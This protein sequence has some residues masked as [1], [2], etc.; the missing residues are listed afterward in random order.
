MQ[1]VDLV[2]QTSDAIVV[3]FD[4]TRQPTLDSAAH[5]RLH[6][7]FLVRGEEISQREV[8]ECVVL[9][10]RESEGKS[11]SA[12]GGIVRGTVAL[13]WREVKGAEALHWRESEG[14]HCAALSQRKVEGTVAQASLPWRAA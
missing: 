5:S 10:W 14:K 9:H 2:L 3:C 6:P 7:Q 12:Y 4:A 11:C 13:H 1:V 8:E